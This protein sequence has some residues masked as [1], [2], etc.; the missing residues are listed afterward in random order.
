VF[1]LNEQENNRCIQKRGHILSAKNEPQ[2]VDSMH[3]TST[4]SITRIN[5]N[6]GPDTHADRL[7]VRK[8]LTKI[9]FSARE[10]ISVRVSIG[11]K[12]WMPWWFFSTEIFYLKQ[13]RSFE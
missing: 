10:K 12:D 11:H 13:T 1:V 9:L 4:E 6:S 8:L 5:H 3:F 2:A 7:F